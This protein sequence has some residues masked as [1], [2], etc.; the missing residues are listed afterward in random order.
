MSTRVAINGLGRIGR[1]I[2]KLVI[3]DAAMDIDRNGRIIEFNPAAERTFGYARDQVLG[4]DV[5]D[6]VIPL[7]MRDAHHRG[8][9][10]YLTTGQ[11]SLLDKR[12]QVTAMRSDGTQFAAEL[13][14]TQV[15]VTPQSLFAA[16]LRDTSKEQIAERE[17]R[18]YASELRVLSHRLVEVQETE[19]RTLANALHDLVGQKLTALNINLTIAE[20]KSAHVMVPQLSACLAD[21]LKLVD[22]T[23]DCIRDV[24]TELRPAVL[25]D[26]GLKAALRWYV[27]QFAKRTGLAATFVEQGTSRRLPVAA[28]EAFF[29]IAQKAL[30]NAAKY[31]RAKKLTVTIA[32]TSDRSPLTIADDGCGFDPLACRRP[33]K[34]HGWGLHIMRDRAA[35]V[36]GEWSVESAPGQGTHVTVSM[37]NDPNSSSVDDH[38]VARGDCTFP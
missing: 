24:M 34:D 3:D 35:A 9:S 7:A 36:G 29:R 21:S 32:A 2:L 4:K 22:E 31:A 19:R 28:E 33:A 25:D 11:S 30:A 27:D 23:S 10:R 18:R 14:V 20:A 15:Q 38:I 8:M 1:A 17:L 6:V 16:S 5:A 37:T 26:Y 13:T 12:V